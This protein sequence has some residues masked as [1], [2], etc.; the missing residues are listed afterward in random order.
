MITVQAQHIDGGPMSAPRRDEL[1]FLAL[2]SHTPQASVRVLTN[3]R[4]LERSGDVPLPRR[5]ALPPPP[6]IPVVDRGPERGP[7]WMRARPGKEFGLH[8]SYRV[9]TPADVE[10]GGRSTSQ[11]N[12]SVVWTVL[13]AFRSART[14]SLPRARESDSN[15]VI[16]NAG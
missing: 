1:L 15:L 16:R 13:T 2:G 7:R 9:V 10:T 5:G 6:A 8:S 3:V 12:A 14:T 11:T 4:C